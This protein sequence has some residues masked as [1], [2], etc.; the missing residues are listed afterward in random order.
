MFDA[1]NETAQEQSRW[2]ANELIPFGK[3]L[4]LDRISIG[5]TA[6]VYR[7][8]A[9][10]EAG[11]ERLAAIKRILPHMAG[12]QEFISTFIQE[13][14]TAARLSHTNICPIFELGKV[15]ESMYMAMEYIIGKD[16]GRINQTLIRKGMYMPPEVAAWIA[17]KMCEALDYAHNLKNLQGE[18]IGFIHRDLSPAN[19]LLSYEGDVKLIDF[20][21]AKAVGQAQ[22]TNVDALKKK[23]SYMSPEMVKGKRLDSRSDI[24]GVG[25]CLRSSFSPARTTSPF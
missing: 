8:I 25:V 16:L 20:G 7:G 12:D 6:A 13:A 15:G 9:Y 19:I 2:S 21:V 3:Y 11:F 1:S 14:K 22:Q 4:L 5:A 23:L 17:S 10:G 18:Q 24:F